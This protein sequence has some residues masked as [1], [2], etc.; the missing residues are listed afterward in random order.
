M[1]AFLVI[2]IR[3]VIPLTILRW[4]LAGGLIAVVVDAVDVALVDA[5][6]TLLGEPPEFGPM[7]STVTR[8]NA[9]TSASSA[10]TSS[11]RSNVPK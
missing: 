10:A 4:P 2:A 1:A 3:I 6:A 7:S 9:A 11:H 8:G 5:F